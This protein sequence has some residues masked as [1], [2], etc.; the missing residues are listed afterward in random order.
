MEW[1]I[2]ICCTFELYC[3]AETRLHCPDSCARIRKT[4]REVLASSKLHKTV[5]E[6][7]MNYRAL[8]ESISNIV[9]KYV[10][11]SMSAGSTWPDVFP[12]KDPCA[13]LVWR[14]PTLHSHSEKYLVVVAPKLAL[15]KQGFVLWPDRIN[16]ASCDLVTMASQLIPSSG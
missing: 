12:S 3:M 4:G 7:I 2:A 14:A 16:D 6:R 15:S 13:S 11:G 8:H 1:R 5:F 9:C 10:K